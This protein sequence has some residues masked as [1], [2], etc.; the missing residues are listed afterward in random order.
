MSCPHL[1]NQKVVFCFILIPKERIFPNQPSHHQPSKVREKRTPHSAM[2][3]E[4]G[5]D[6]CG[7]GDGTQICT[8]CYR[9]ALSRK[10]VFV[11]VPRQSSVSRVNEHWYKDTNK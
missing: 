6:G 11:I 9:F 10:F 5:D 8:D 4:Q 2:M 7:I 1:L 3:G